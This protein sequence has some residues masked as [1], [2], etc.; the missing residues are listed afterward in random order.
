[1]DLLDKYKL[2]PFQVGYVTFMHVSLGRSLG[3][4]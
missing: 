2:Y 4:A 3:V 1:M